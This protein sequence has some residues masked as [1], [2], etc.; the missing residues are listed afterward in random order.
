M[1]SK[2]KKLPREDG[3]DTFKSP[4][5]RIL[6]LMPLGFLAFVAVVVLVM[7]LG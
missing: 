5:V 6:W 3:D 4:I 7:S 1:G 2:G